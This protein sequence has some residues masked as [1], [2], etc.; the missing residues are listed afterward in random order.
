MNKPGELRGENF[1]FSPGANFTQLST[2]LENVVNQRL[3]SLPFRN[4]QQ[5]L[6]KLVL[7]CLIVN[8]GRKPE[9]NM[10]PALL[11]MIGPYPY[12]V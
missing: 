11:A 10:L 7:I 5:K 6:K 3:K 8:I 9:R 2:F 1:P 4:K 12:C